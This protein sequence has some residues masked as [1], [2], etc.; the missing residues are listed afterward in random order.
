MQL[1]LSKQNNRIDEVIIQFVDCYCVMDDQMNLLF[2]VT[3]IVDSEEEF[4]QRW[5]WLLDEQGN[6][7]CGMFFRLCNTKMISRLQFNIK[8]LVT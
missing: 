8:L 2:R 3:Q 7:N 6:Y 1:N 4:I 5:R